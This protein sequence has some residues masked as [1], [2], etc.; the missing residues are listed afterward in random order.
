MPWYVTFSFLYNA[1]LTVAFFYSQRAKVKLGMVDYE[2]VDRL[3][4][5]HVRMYLDGCGGFLDH[6]P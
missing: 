6:V 3:V 1:L 4:G 2:L 5:T